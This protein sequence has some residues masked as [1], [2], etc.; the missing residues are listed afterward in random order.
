MAGMTPTFKISD[1]PQKVLDLLTR[2]YFNQVRMRN[3]V[4]END[5]FTHKNLIAV[6]EALTSDN[7]KLG[8][9]LFG[10]P[11]NGKTTMMYAI[12]RVIEYYERENH[13]TYMGQWFRGNPSFK[14]AREIY[15]LV[16]KAREFNDMMQT[17]ILCI[18]DLAEEPK[19]Y[20]EFG[21]VRTPM[22]DVLMHRYRFKLYTLV[23]SNLKPKDLSAKYDE[24]VAD[25]C[26]EMFHVVPFLASTY[27]KK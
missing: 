12:M 14:T 27:R 23:T 20:I 2:H 15:A 25:R 26:R 9:W 11:G 19:E 24:R 5:E 17:D 3:V 1:D 8:I 6:A 21:N 22:M 18:D 10:K 7:P 13:F 4:F 16:T